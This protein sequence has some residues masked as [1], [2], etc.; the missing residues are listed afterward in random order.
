MSSIRYSIAFFLMTISCATW[1]AAQG[2]L[3]AAATPP[4]P[5]TKLEAFRPAAGTVLTIGYDPLGSV[6]SISVNARELRD[7]KGVSVHGMVVKVTQSQY[8]EERAF[9]DAD[10]LPELLRGID[11]LLDVSSN[12]TSFKQF[13]VRYPTRGELQITAFN[14]RGGIMYAVQTGRITEAQTFI[15]RDELVALRAMFVAAQQKLGGATGN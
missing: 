1:G 11:A 2:A 6:G 9:V 3:P 14:N 15:S 10:E 13:E 7:G 8:R 5:A 12:P 4:P